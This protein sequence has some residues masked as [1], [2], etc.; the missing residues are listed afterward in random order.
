MGMGEASNQLAGLQGSRTGPVER[1]KSTGMGSPCYL[2]WGSE[3]RSLNQAAEPAWVGQRAAKA[4][5]DRRH[6]NHSCQ[7]PS[8]KTDCSTTLPGELGRA[9]RSLEQKMPR[10]GR[11]RITG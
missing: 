3:S 10:D 8:S 9:S 4:F 11:Q 6:N 5:A 1:Y 2:A 7:G